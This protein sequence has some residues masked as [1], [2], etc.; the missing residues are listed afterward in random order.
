MSEDYYERVNPH[1]LAALTDLENKKVLEIGCAAGQLGA[2]IKQN[3]QVHWTGVE[4]TEDAHSKASKVLDL[5]LL[6]NIET[7][8]LD[9]PSQSFDKLVLGDV[10]EHLRDPWASLNQLREYLKPGG[11]VICSLPNINHWTVLADLL[12]GQFTYED[13]GILDRTHPR[14]FTLK[15]AIALFE[16]AGF[17]LERVESIEVEHPQMKRVVGQFNS[18]RNILGIDHANFEREARTYQWLIHAQKSAG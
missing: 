2:A 8:S 14:F 16:E 5:A 7:D 18:L 15:E 17:V 13:H 11:Q 3:T 4:I 9:L 12:A 6:A 10:L 1:L